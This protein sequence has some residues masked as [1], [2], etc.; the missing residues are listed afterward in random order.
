MSSSLAC[1]APGYTSNTVIPV[2]AGDS[3]EGWYQHVIGGG[4]GANDPVRMPL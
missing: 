2:K 4:Q 3:I 1:G